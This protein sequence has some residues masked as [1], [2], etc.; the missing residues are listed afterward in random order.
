MI[1]T[2][3]SGGGLEP[4]RTADGLPLKVALSRAQRRARV[5]AFLLVAPLL[6]FVAFTFVVP[7]SQMLF[8]S[9]NNTQFSANMLNLGQW[10]SD[11]PAG[12][13]IA[14]PA[15]AMLVADLK[16]AAAARTIG[17]VGTRINYD[18]P[19]TR[20]LFTSA[21]RRVADLQ[22]PFKK[23][24]LEF[25]PRWGSA[26]LW[27]AMR[28]ASGALTAN[29]YLAAL[30]HKRDA[31]GSI[32]PK[33]PDQRIHIPLFIRTF[34][35]AG[36][37]TLNCLI[38]AYPVAHLLATVSSRSANLLMIVV[39]LP[40]WTSLLVRTTSWM[41]LLQGQGVVNDLLVWI[42][43]VSDDGRL[44]MMYNQLGT[45]VTMTH[46]LLPFAILPLY[47][48]MKAIPATYSRAARSLGANAWTTF[49]RVY[50]P[51]TLPGISA[52]AILVFILAIGYYITPALVGG[53]AGQ[54]ISNQIAFH[55]LNS[56]NWS[57]AA[58]LA[59][60]LLSSVIVLYWIYDRVIGLDKIKLS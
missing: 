40:F 17:Q 20:S 18:L 7:I 44:A 49:R 10:F 32:V 8:R 45:I 34:V 1:E 47:S 22:P 15:Y 6:L 46:I 12:S 59:V 28:G 43:I 4:L 21:G 11:N 26:E 54:L 27:A 29:F 19:G 35:L 16:Q 48:V 5:R 53:A 24:M 58:A 25:D 60:L 51:L 38:L 55:M 52:G 13:P 41:V 2:E 3:G 50:F 30:D 42:G 14:E 36:T 23:A 9:V 56:L 31:D 37:I 33:K 39:L 57:L